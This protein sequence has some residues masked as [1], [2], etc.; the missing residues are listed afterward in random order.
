[1]RQTESPQTQVGRGMRDAAQT[2]LYSVYTLV[3][4]HLTELKLKQ[5]KTFIVRK[6]KYGLA[7][8]Q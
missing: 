8:E 1:M 3:D 4:K 6:C 2:V 5:N 7:T